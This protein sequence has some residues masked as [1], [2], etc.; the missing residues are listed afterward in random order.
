MAALVRAGSRPVGTAQ[1]GSSSAGTC[2]QGFG[3][4]RGL[5]SACGVCCGLV[6][7]PNRSVTL[8]GR[9][10]VRSCPDHTLFMQVEVRKRSQRLR[11]VNRQVLCLVGV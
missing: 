9:L 8:S 3:G 2:L 7:G 10:T 11:R 5:A 1:L 4:L 6:R